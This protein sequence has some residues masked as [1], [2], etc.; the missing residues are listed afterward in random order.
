MKKILLLF[1]I[2]LLGLAFLQ[3]SCKKK[4][5]S[6]IQEEPRIIFGATFAGGQY[7]DSG[8]FEVDTFTGN[9]TKFYTNGEYDEYL[10]LIGKEENYRKGKVCTV[11]FERGF[12]GSVPIKFIGKNNSQK[13]DICGNPVSMGDTLYRTAFIGNRD[14]Y[15]KLFGTYVGYENDNPNPITVEIYKDVWYP[16]KKGSSQQGDSTY[17]VSGLMI[18][19]CKAMYSFDEI[20]GIEEYN[21]DTRTIISPMYKHFKSIHNIWNCKAGALS[22]IIGQIDNNNNLVINYIKNT[23]IDPKSLELLENQKRIYKTFKGKKVQ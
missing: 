7:T 2:P 13:Y 3:L 11:I 18:N 17:F 22:E 10:W 23:K 8:L 21:L 15:S 1:L 5:E 14:K 20:N 12:E 9:V 6:A 4:C 19:E 16:W